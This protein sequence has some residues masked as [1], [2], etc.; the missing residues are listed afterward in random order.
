MVLALTFVSFTAVNF[1]LVVVVV[2]CHFLAH[3][4]CSFELIENLNSMGLR[5]FEYSH[6]F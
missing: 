2:D 5:N 3:S 6:Y 1:F 4:K